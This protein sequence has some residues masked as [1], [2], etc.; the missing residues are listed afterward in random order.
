VLKTHPKQI[1]ELTLNPAKLES[2]LSS[3]E[4][5][6]VL[7]MTKTEFYALPAWKQKKK[8]DEVDLL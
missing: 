6:E 5:E 7:Q 1:G 3:A 2:Y 4:F 8:R